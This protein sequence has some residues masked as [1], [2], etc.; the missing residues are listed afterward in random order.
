MQLSSLPPVHCISTPPK[1]IL[2]HKRSYRFLG[3][4]S[5]EGVGGRSHFSSSQT[6]FPGGGIKRISGVASQIRGMESCLFMNIFLLHLLIKIYKERVPRLPKHNTLG[7][8]SR[9]KLLFFWIF[10]QIRGGRG[11]YPIFFC[12]FGQYKE[13][14]SYKMPII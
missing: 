3:R 4:S 1:C 9:K 12:V 2:L 8:I 13:S 14:I 6:K 5:N 7:T 10:F 11:P